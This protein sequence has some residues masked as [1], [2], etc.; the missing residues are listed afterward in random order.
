MTFA[1][2]PTCSMAEPSCSTLVFDLDDA[3]AI[4][5]TMTVVCSVD[6]PNADAASVTMSDAAASSILPAAAR[7]RTVGSILMDFSVS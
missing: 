6:S 3:I 7:F 1:V 2:P 5:S 4:W